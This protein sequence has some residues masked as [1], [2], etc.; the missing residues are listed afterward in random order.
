[1]HSSR[2]RTA[3]AVA[4]R[5]VSARHPPRDQTPQDQM[6][7]KTRHP[8]GPDTPG[9]RHPLG[10]DTPPGPDTTPQDQ[11]PQTRPPGT[12]TPGTRHPPWDQAPPVNRMTD[13][14]KN[15]TLHQTSFTGG[16]KDCLVKLSYNTH[17]SWDSFH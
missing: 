6:A 14:C 10:P 16:N 1:M 3:T 8:P 4:V 7:T 11:T 12:R 9:T 2:K 13:R 15:I 5:G 17:L